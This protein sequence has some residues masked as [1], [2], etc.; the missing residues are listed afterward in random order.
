MQLHSVTFGRRWQAIRFGTFQ[1]SMLRP[2]SSASNSFAVA[3]HPPLLSPVTD[4]KLS[5]FFVV[6][7]LN[8]T[9][10]Q[11]LYDCEVIQLNYFPGQLSYIF[12]VLQNGLLF[13]TIQKK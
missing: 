3:L 10:F 11:S 6:R 8:K 4:H 9:N 2:V 7:T 13:N 5:I 1:A 12:P